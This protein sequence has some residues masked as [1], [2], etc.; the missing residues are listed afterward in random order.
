M[1]VAMTMT[2]SR[3]LVQDDTEGKNEE[4]ASEATEMH[5]EEA[6]ALRPIVLRGEVLEFCCDCD[7]ATSSA[8]AGAGHAEEDLAAYGAAVWGTLEDIQSDRGWVDVAVAAARMGMSE[9]CGRTL[10]QT[11]RSVVPGSL[12]RTTQMGGTLL[13]PVPVLVLLLVTSRALAVNGS[14]FASERTMHAAKLLERLVRSGRI[15]HLLAA[16]GRTRHVPDEEGDTQV[17]TAGEADALGVL[18]RARTA[19]CRQEHRGSVIGESF[20]VSTGLFLDRNCRYVAALRSL[21]PA[22]ARRRG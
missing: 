15:V 22:S 20:S 6:Q 7:D 1:A 12:R 5:G 9:R 18:F 2:M 4:G 3:D 16:G 14:P 10:A 13:V 19:P 21:D 17:V 11:V 8:F